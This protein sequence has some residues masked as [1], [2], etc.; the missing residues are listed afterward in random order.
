MSL[1]VKWVDTYAFATGDYTEDGQVG[2]GSNPSLLRNWASN[3]AFAM[4]STG[5]QQLTKENLPIFLVR[6]NVLQA[7]CGDNTIGFNPDVYESFVGARTNVTPE[8]DAVFFRRMAKTAVGTAQQYREQ[9]AD[10]IP[11]DFLHNLKTER[12]QKGLCL[13]CKSHHDQ[14]V[15]HDGEKS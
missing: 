12:L 9:W 2:D 7:A 14:S 4:M 1:N 11:G 10:R 8:T 5:I 3:V 13:T 6:L 15:V